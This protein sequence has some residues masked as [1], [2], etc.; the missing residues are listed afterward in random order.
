MSCKICIKKVK[1]IIETL[2]FQNAYPK[3]LLTERKAR[4]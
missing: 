4:P 3:T 1:G 2:Q